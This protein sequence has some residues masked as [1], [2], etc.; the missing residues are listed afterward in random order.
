MRKTDSSGK[1]SLTTALS[2]RALARSWPKGFS[3]TT[4]RHAPSTGCARPDLDSCSQTVGK[5][6]GGIDR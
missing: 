3:I 5:A 6:F 2:S 4:R 1:T